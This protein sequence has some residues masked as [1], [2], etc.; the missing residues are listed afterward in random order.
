M[1][2]AMTSTIAPPLTTRGA[3]GLDRRAFSIAD[4]ERMFEAGVLDRDEKF[5]LIRGEIVP[6]SPQRRLHSVLRNRLARWL[7]AA[8]P[9]TIEVNPETTVRLGDHQLFDADILL[10][11]PLPMDRAYTSLA[12]AFLVIEVAD[13]T[14]LRD[15]RVKAL[16]YAKVGLPELWIVHVEAQETLQLRAPGPQGY[17]ETTAVPFAAALS[18]LC[19][20]Q[21]RLRLAELAG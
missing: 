18:S 14:F 8:L 9:S 17:G 12:E 4:I 1:L 13:T 6:M 21:V 2:W 15:K 16:E 11:R 20:P 19:A 7:T 5:E 3:E 10:S